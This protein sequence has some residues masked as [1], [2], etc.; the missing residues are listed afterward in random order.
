MNFKFHLF[1]TFS[2]CL[3]PNIS[4]AIIISGKRRINT[5]AKWSI[6]NRLELTLIIIKPHICNNSF[7]VEVIFF[8][9]TVNI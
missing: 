7:I 5:N 4:P 9:I 6:D 3:G 2:F 1:K 8:P